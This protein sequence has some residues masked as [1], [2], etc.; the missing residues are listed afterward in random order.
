[1][2]IFPLIVLLSLSPLFM[3]GQF[4][5]DDILCMMRSES[6]NI[7]K[8]P[9]QVSEQLK[10]QFKTDYRHYKNHI[11]VECVVKFNNNKLIERLDWVKASTPPFYTV[12]YDLFIPCKG[13]R[14]HQ[15][16]L[17]FEI[18]IDTMGKL[19]RPVLL[20]ANTNPKRIIPYNKALKIAN[21]YWPSKMK[22]S[23]LLLL[24]ITL[25]RKNR[26]FSTKWTYLTDYFYFNHDLVYDSNLKTF[27]WIF[28]KQIEPPP[29]LKYIEE[30]TSVTYRTIRINAFSGEVISVD[31]H[32]SPPVIDLTK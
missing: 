26:D 31:E 23:D 24:W 2:K 22:D 11:K 30:N 4:T 13:L 1:M 9:P 17:P 18:V 20:P 7:K 28:Q 16:Y 27:K 6:A 25:F 21:Q 10:H 19:A 3:R 15:I 29:N 5:T 12:R 32:K 14:L 8:L